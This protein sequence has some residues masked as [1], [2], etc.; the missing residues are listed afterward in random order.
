MIFR[1]IKYSLLI[2]LDIIKAFTEYVHK[3]G[4]VFQVQIGLSVPF[5]VVAS[6]KAI[7][8]ILGST[9]HLEKSED[10]NFL[11]SWLGTGLVTSAGNK[12]KKH[13]RIITPTFHFKVLEDFVEVF[14]STGDI[15]MN[16]LRKEVGKASFDIVPFFSMFALDAIC[17]N[18]P[19][20]SLKVVIIP[21]I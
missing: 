11:H 15:L 17:G 16:K 2:P 18:S 14:N 7:E 19:L 3:C 9:K 20:F 8:C 10:Y 13:R 21:S 12:W 4:D 6:P 5:L 1:L